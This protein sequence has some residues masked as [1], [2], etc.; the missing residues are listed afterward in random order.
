M[1]TIKRRMNY[2]NRMKTE[3]HSRMYDNRQKYDGYDG[4]ISDLASPDVHDRDNPDYKSRNISYQSTNKDKLSSTWGKEYFI[5][6]SLKKSKRRPFK[7]RR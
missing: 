5:R 1:L 7:K 4:Y 2:L 3:R 6:K